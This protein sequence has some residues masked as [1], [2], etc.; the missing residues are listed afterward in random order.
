MAPLQEGQYMIQTSSQSSARLNL[1]H[2]WVTESLGYLLH[3]SIPVAPDAKIADIATGTGA[4]PVSYSLHAAVPSSVQIDGFD[5]TDDMF[6]PADWLPSNVS[7]R[8]LDV[9]KPIPAELKGVY[10][11]VCI[12]YFGVQVRNNDPSGVLANLV[13]MLKPG[14][15]IQWV[16]SDIYSQRVV[17]PTS[18]TLPESTALERHLAVWRRYLDASGLRYD[19][20]AA[21]PT[22]CIRHGMSEA[23]IYTPPS[24]PAL[25]FTLTTAVLGAWEELSYN[26]DK[27]KE[28]DEF[29]GSGRELREKIGAFWREVEAGAALEQRFF[30]TVARK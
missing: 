4:W 13:E 29:L 15:Y 28:P 1:Q 24:T 12:R 17:K 25:R 18:C 5:V 11:V 7:L 27:D 30:V 16:E 19:W 10:D 20:L 8:T 14:G 3:P 9:L 2:Y 6:P 26:L 22:H 21:L 23:H